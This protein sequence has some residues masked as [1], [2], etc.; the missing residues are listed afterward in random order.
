MASRSCGSI[1][2]GRGPSYRKRE[3]LNPLYA[4]R[5]YHAFKDAQK[6]FRRAGKAAKNF[7]FHSRLQDLQAAANS[8]DS[9]ALYAGIRAIA[10]KHA[11]VKV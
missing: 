6:A 3:I 7:W 2:N 5:C 8:G 11:R 4:A 1:V 9:R 10:P